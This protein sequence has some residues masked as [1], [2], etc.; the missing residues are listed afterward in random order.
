VR[1]AVGCIHGTGA[2]SIFTTETSSE[3]D[4]TQ[5]LQMSQPGSMRR[6]DV[7]LR[8]DVGTVGEIEGWKEGCLDRQA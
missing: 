5:L 2:S 4:E 3:P 8:A 1:A 6:A 7:A